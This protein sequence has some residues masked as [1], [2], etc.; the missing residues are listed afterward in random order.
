MNGISI[1]GTREIAMPK[2]HAADPVITRIFSFDI[3][4]GSYALFEK[5]NHLLLSESYAQALFGS[6]DALQKKITIQSGEDTIQLTVAGVYRDFPKNSH[7]AFN[8]I[9]P[10][11]SALLN[12]LG[13]DTNETAVYGKVSGDLKTCE[14]RL[15]SAA[16]RD[17]EYKLQPLTDIYF[18]PRAL[19]EDAT[20][21]DQYSVLILIAVAALI[22]FLALT[23]YINLTTLTLPHRAKEL[24]IKKLAGTSPV[25]MF[26]MFLKEST[27]VVVSSFVLGIVLLVA[28][29]AF[30]E[31]ILAID[32]NSLF[33][34]GDRA[35]FIVAG[36]LVVIAIVSPL[37]LTW[38]F[39]KATPNKLL[40]TEQ[41]TFPRLK[42]IITIT[43]LGISIFLIVSSMV[44]SRQINYSLIK[45]PGRNHDQVVYLDY[46]DGLTA[47]GLARLREG[48]RVNNPNILD[49]I[50]ISHL[51]DRINSKELYSPFYVL[52]VDRNFRDFFNLNMITGRWFD[53]N[54]RDSIFAVNER[55]M[56]HT[57]KNDKHN[58]GVIDDI[59]NDFNLPQKPTKFR[60]SSA[61][62]YNYLCV[63][64]LEVEIRQTV[65][66]LSSIFGADVFFL[67]KRFEGWLRYQDRLNK[68]SGLLA[69]VS[70]LLS[71]CAIYGLSIGLIRD[72][73]KKIA[74]HKI[75]GANT[76]NITLLLAREFIRDMLI[77]VLIFGPVTYIIM[78]EFL[79]TFVYATQFEWQDPIFP[80]SY[81][82]IVV[83]V[84]CGFQAMSLSKKDL[85]TALKTV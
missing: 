55:G 80:L 48:W 2:I 38:R 24:A 26:L 14:S 47:E 50:G 19:G 22:L 81:C 7:D 71:C 68:L 23:N 43:Q 56:I 21:G 69:I 52:A 30:V 20:H 78:N 39:I 11:D 18:G 9:M 5:G 64:V 73:I 12:T 29:N 25:S 62:D 72:K 60:L 61:S 36:G 45:E 79:R 63:R 76:A 13:F 8:F 1:R 82:V 3:L 10:M 57:A 84:L 4:Q 65:I 37:F 42:K 51:P 44:I 54:S 40:G 28:T 46:P 31:P 17:V 49:V 83:G 67:N 16:G 59:S 27:M 15:T 41:I 6:E 33:L 53:A 77:A 66:N 35:L 85:T 75:Y 58:V 70:G 32:M 74:V 34:K